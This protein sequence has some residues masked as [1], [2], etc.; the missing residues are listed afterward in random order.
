[1]GRRRHRHIGTWR[2]INL[3]DERATGKKR[4]RMFRVMLVTQAAAALPSPL[5]INPG[6]RSTAERAKER[7][8]FALLILK[9]AERQVK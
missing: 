3:K 5:I 7:V 4:E 1:M 8:A 2:P 9:E 6:A